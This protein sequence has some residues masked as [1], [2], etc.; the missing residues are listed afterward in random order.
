MR[1]ILKVQIE[2]KTEE[3]EKKRD[4]AGCFVLLTNVPLHGDMAASDSELLQS[5]KEQYGIERNFSFLKDP[6]DSK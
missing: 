1:Y 5:Y 4:E 3:I 6:P 2:E